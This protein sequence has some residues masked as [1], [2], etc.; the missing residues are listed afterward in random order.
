MATIKEMENKNKTMICRT[1]G[2][3]LEKLVTN[4][5]FKISYDSIVIIKGLPV[6]QCQNC[7]EYLIEDEVME[8][9]D[10]ILSKIDKTAELEVFSYAV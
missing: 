6:L 1:C 3:K 9:V 4:L 10:S 2:G 8:R 7:S 5:P